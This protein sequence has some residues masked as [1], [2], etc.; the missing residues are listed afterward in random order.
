MRPGILQ[1]SWQW[2]E[3]LCKD[4][5]HSHPKHCCK[6][7]IKCSDSGLREAAGD[8]SPEPPLA[9]PA[10][11]WIG[12]SSRMCLLKGCKYV[13]SGSQI[14]MSVTE[15]TRSAP[16]WQ[17]Q[18]EWEEKCLQVLNQLL[19]NTPN[20]ALSLMPWTLLEQDFQL[21]TWIMLL[22][23]LFLL[24][25]LLA[26]HPGHPTSQLSVTVQLSTPIPRV[27]CYWQYIPAPDRY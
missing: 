7:A 11:V 14:I 12:T 13:K 1:G 4:S 10:E 17:T 3:N 27:S 21:Q 16:V 22:L 9:A 6:S 23:C 26:T 18:A 8:S 2:L 20:E 15:H 24:L 19:K 25:F 5:C